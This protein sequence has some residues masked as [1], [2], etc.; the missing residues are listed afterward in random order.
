[1][2]LKDC[3]EEESSMLTPV[4]YL[5]ASVVSAESWM[6]VVIR[7][8][9]V[10]TSSGC[11][12]LCLTVVVVHAELCCTTSLLAEYEQW[13]ESKLLLVSVLEFLPHSLLAC[14]SWRFVSHES[15]TFARN[16]Q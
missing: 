2:G 3:V 9:P 5:V 7:L 4:F 6:D 8:F 1:V 10:T 12:G 13:A 16:Q 14:W 11:C 15:V